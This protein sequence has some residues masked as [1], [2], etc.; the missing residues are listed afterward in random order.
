MLKGKIW[1]IALVLLIPNLARA[2]YCPPQGK[3]GVWSKEA[4]YLCSRATKEGL[5]RDIRVYSPDRG[6]AVHV[7]NDHWFVEVG[8]NRLRLNTEE[9]YISYY[10][11]ELSWAPDSAAF[12]ITQSDAT[13]EINGFHTELYKVDE[14][15]L[16]R[17]QDIWQVVY[18]RF[19]K[20]HK[21]ADEDPNVA[22]LKWERG[23]SQI[24]VIAEVP[25]DSVGARREYFGGYVMSTADSK[26]IHEYTPQELFRRWGGVFGLRL[27]GDYHDLHSAERKEE[28]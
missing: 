22:G 23:S 13:S 25:A 10:P 6:K 27:K 15:A 7:V 3:P 19:A 21:M 16:R 11:A 8:K 1:L 28:P 18:D 26:V 9:S 2:T 5:A 20:R 24:I 14:K 4:T 17:M 12:Y